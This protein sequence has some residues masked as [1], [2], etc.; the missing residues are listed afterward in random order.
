MTIAAGI[1][2]GQWI[3]SRIFMPVPE[4]RRRRRLRGSDGKRRRPV[5]V[6]VLLL[7]LPVLLIFG[8]TIAT[9]RNVPFKPASR[10]SWAIRLRRSRSPRWWRSTFSASAA[11]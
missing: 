4:D 10:C 2:Y 8:A 11:A 6:V 9:L 7:I 3:A 5:P 1:V